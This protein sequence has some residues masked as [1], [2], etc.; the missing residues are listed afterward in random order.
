MTF[1]A[2]FTFSLSEKCLKST[3]SKKPGYFG[4][5]G[6]FRSFLLVQACSSSH[7]LKNVLR[8]FT[9]QYL[10]EPPELSTRAASVKQNMDRLCAQVASRVAEWVVCWSLLEFRRIDCHRDCNALTH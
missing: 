2:Y 10:M 9:D 3:F 7:K 6:A 1:E 4:T 5:Y 8:R